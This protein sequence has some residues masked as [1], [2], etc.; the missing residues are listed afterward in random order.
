ME[1]IHIISHV[2][3]S[4]RTLTIGGGAEGPPEGGSRTLSGGS[5]GGRGPPQR[6]RGRGPFRG[7]SGGVRGRGPPE[8]RRRGP[9][10]VDREGLARAPWRVADDPIGWV[11]GA[12][13][14]LLGGLGGPS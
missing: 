9:F 13:G 12:E 2:R 4:V 14:T 5:G 6:G 1:S 3:P 7:G 11:G 8:R 10:W